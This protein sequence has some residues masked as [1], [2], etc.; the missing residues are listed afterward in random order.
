MKRKPKLRP[1]QRVGVFFIDEF[2]G[3]VLLADEQGLGK[4]IQVLDWLR[5]YPK[6]RPVV[7]VCPAS[8]KYVWEEQ[9]REHCNLRTTVCYSQKPPKKKLLQNASIFII[10]YDILL[11]WSRYLRALHPQVVIFDEIQKI[12]NRGTIRTRAARLLCSP[13]R[14]VP[15][16]DLRL[17]DN[18][19]YIQED[20]LVAFEDDKHPDK[21]E[22]H[23]IVNSLTKKHARVKVQTPHLMGL[24]GTPLTNRPKELWSSL[25]L[26]WPLYFPAF[27][28]FAWDY[29]EPEMTAYGWTFNGASNLP[30]LHKKLKRIGMIRRLKKD[31]AKDLPSKQI[32]VIPM[33][34]TNRKEY[35]EASTNFINWLH[36]KNTA[37]AERA[38]KAKRITQ[39]A[40]LKRLAAEG[41]LKNVIN[42][43]DTFLETSDSKLV[44]GCMHH[45][46]INA[47]HK[48]YK[49]KSVTFTGKTP[50]KKRHK[51]IMD[52][53]NNPQ[54]RIFTGQIQAAGTGVDGLQKVSHTSAIVE[55][56]WEPGTLSQ[57]FDRIHRIG[58]EQNVNIY[59]FIAK[60]TIEEKLCEIIQTKQ[61]ILTKI[62]DGKSTTKDEEYM[63]MNIYNQL[64]KEMTKKK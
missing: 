18:E 1:Y 58:Q 51:A 12:K 15:L 11:H 5:R 21:K 63:Q 8:V 29:C 45:K 20:S 42:W 50:P 59:I 17:L 24:S 30:K 49:K 38:S 33:D 53:R 36:R 37:K 34:I 40:Y 61:E 48:K 60:N 35:K 25:N 27:T 2:N 16:K 57:F 55:L 6:K 4:T 31:V 9:A 32:T 13:I 22:L 41:K 19:K 56:P 23:G 52:F 44:L 64:I 7:I 10:N 3:R 43:I 14:K 54:R 26:I 39:I 62:L 47:I 28:T 46:I